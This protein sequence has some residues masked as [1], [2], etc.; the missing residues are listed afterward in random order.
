MTGRSR[1]SRA[2][3]SRFFLFRTG[4]NRGASPCI[5]RGCADGQPPA[6]GLSQAPIAAISGLTPMM[7]NT[8]VRLSLHSTKGQIVIDFAT[9]GDLDR[10]RG[11][12]ARP[13]FSK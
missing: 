4:G 9:V 8:R 10:I 13:C 3:S 5:L 11:E 1:R 12:L 2:V 7:F 6:L